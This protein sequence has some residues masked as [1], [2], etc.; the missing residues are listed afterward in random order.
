MLQNK[1]Y[2]VP[3]VLFQN[4]LCVVSILTLG[5]QMISDV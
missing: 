1:A 2:A 5:V 4:V 3:R